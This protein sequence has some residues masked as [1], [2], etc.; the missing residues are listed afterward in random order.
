[1]PTET[2]SLGYL[3]GNATAVKRWVS[4]RM[5]S[6]CAKLNCRMRRESQRPTREF[7]QVALMLISV[8]DK[9]AI[10]ARW[11]RSYL[12]RLP[13]SVSVRQPL[14]RVSYYRDKLPEKTKSQETRSRRFRD[15]HHPKHD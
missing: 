9:S 11:G 4:F 10:V 3:V 5:S 8:S 13:V 14:Q 2:S 12:I 1:M 15:I 6:L 7:S